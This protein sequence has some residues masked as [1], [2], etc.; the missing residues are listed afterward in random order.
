MLCS[1]N[2]IT[3]SS[4]GQILA[5]TFFA[6]R[7][8]KAAIQNLRGELSVISAKVPNTYQRFIEICAKMA[9]L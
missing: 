3:S 4:T 5:V 8:K 7:R 2:H 9:F 1:I 6:K